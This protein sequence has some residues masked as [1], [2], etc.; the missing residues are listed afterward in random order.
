MPVYNGNGN[1]GNGQKPG[2]A[3]KPGQPLGQVPLQMPG[4]GQPVSSVNAVPFPPSGSGGYFC[5][6]CMRRAPHRFCK[7]KSNPNTYQLRSTQWELPPQQHGF[8][9]R[10]ID[11]TPQ[12]VLYDPDTI[13][14]GPEFCYQISP[15]GPTVLQQ[16]RVETSLYQQREGY[17]LTPYR[18]LEPLLEK[19]QHL[20]P[21]YDSEIIYVPGEAE[22]P[23]SARP[24]ALPGPP[25]T[26]VIFDT[27]PGVQTT[28]RHISVGVNDALS[29]PAIGVSVTL[30]GEPVKYIATPTAA[31]SPPTYGVQPQTP[32]F[33]DPIGMPS[34][35]NDLLIIPDRKRVLIQAIN[36]D[37]TATRRVCISVWGWITPF[38]GFGR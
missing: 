20:Y 10:D 18:M 23:P 2:N 32:N 7:P 22:I 26:V 37:F 21:R 28:I 3:K 12:E 6:D 25:V 29:P 5:E 9:R 15:P 19:L 30:D 36:F 13:L 27:P 17:N 8:P 31:T 14:G 11:I 33:P 4:N 24:P 16:P 35:H 1:N 34:F 38:T